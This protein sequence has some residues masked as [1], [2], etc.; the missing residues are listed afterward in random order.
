MNI[1]ILNNFDLLS[2]GIAI[3]GIGILGFVVFFSGSRSSTNKSFLFFS[4]LTII[5]GISNYLNYQIRSPDLALWVLRI[6]LFI[7]VWHAFSFFLLSSVFPKEEI[8]FSKIFKF[9]VL[10]LV[11]LTSVLMLTPLG[12][13]KISALPSPGEAAS[14]ERGP[15]IPLFGGLA[16]FLIVGGVFLL[17]KKT[18]RSTRAERNQF[19]FILFGALTTF[20]LIA[21]FNLVLPIVFNELKFIPL[22]AVFIF[23]FVAFTAHAI[24]KYHL[25]N[26]RVIAAEILMFLVVIVSFSEIIFARGSLEVALR[27]VIFAILLFF[28]TLLIRS[29]RREVEQRERLEEL[30]REVERVNVELTQANAKLK[31]FDEQKSEFVSLV[32]HQLRAPLTVIKGYVSLIMDGTVKPSTKKEKEVLEKVMFSTEQLVKLV[33]GLLDL[34]R[35][36]S[37]KI[38]YEFVR[39]DFTKMV[40]EVIDKFRQNA[41][42]KKITIR[43]QDGDDAPAHAGAPKMLTYD[44]DKMR[45]VVI[46]L[47]DNAIKYSGENSEVRVHEE[48]VPGS[49][50]EDRVRLTVVDSGLGIKYEDIE[51]LFVK[52]SRTDEAKAHDPGGIGIGLYFLKRVVEDHGGTVGV[53]SGGIGKGSTFWIELPAGNS[54]QN[55]GGGRGT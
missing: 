42:R 33:S 38:K 14:T 44:A 27:A 6:H 16:M 3:A 39:G 46:N 11:I 49:N 12:F 21:V 53:S 43:F 8:R 51:K 28:G 5:W 19:R 1:N 47:I 10:P 18:I 22:G 34:S 15:A 36:E 29:V 54:I 45:E 20:S 23:P 4:L 50:G 26:I 52:F 55:V 25:L 37:G 24:I 13:S 7:S 41:E 35:I 2:V 30:T 32:G 9:G 31:E 40:H 48:R 17:L